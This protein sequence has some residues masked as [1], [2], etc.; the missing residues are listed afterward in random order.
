MRYKL[1]T[2]D[3][4]A[5]LVKL[6]VAP[7]VKYSQVAAMYGIICSKE[8]LRKAYYPNFYHMLKVH[9]NFGKQTGMTWEEWWK[10]LI[11]K[12][13]KDARCEAEKEK[14]DILVTQLIDVY[15]TEF[16]WQPQP[17]AFHLLA[18]LSFKGV[19]MG[20]ISN[21]DPRLHDILGNIRM[22]PYFRFILTSYELGFE[23][24]DARVFRQAMS[25][26]GRMGLKSEECL[27][28]GDCV[29]SDYFAAINNKWKGVLVRKD[30]MQFRTHH[31]SVNP[32]D[33]FPSLF[34]LME[35]IAVQDDPHP[36]MRSRR[37]SQKRQ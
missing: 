14:I 29:I 1:V 23:K 22:T 37:G 19:S 25:L 30:T 5:T 13:F 11:S 6:R 9:P 28:I 26:A 10:E 17:G 34:D 36:S 24:P 31:P 2:F 27:H 4:L 7:E 16:C 20:V 3:A 21:F 8:A 15:K 12:T 32:K 35:F 18:F 33:V